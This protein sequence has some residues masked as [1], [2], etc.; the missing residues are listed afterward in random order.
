MPHEQHRDMVQSYHR[1]RTALGLLGMGLPL[2]LILGGLLDA[3]HLEP[4]ISDFYHTT[5]RDIFVGTLCAI[6][7]FLI[8]Y[9]GYG[10]QSGD[11]ID[12]D[13]LGT[14]AG[15]SAFGVALF[16]NE[17]PTAQIATMTQKMVGISTSPMFHYASALV[18][19]S[20]L[21]VF[22]LKKFTRTAKPVRKRIYLFCGW[23]IVASLVGIAVASA[24]K[25]LGSG[26]PK[27]AVISYNL[28]FW[29]EAIGI[30]AFGLSWL[31]KG[32]ADIAL[33]KLA[34]QGALKSAP[35]A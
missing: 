33:V 26:A 32:K 1:V 13:W 22:C 35:D 2:V 17:S 12:D 20:C 23:V 16:P 7:V 9:R 28:V 14:I 8:C 31:V 27:A 30:W 4:S 11:M 29:L 3:R 34:R 18:F 6:G 24:I 10:R 15:M 25:I 5:Y 21:A 19:F